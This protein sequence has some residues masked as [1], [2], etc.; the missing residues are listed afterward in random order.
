MNALSIITIALSAAYGALMV[1]YRVGWHRQQRA[2]PEPRHFQSDA[3]F[4]I[5]VPARNEAENILPLLDSIF[6]QRFPPDA[7]EAILVDDHSTDAT[8]S[9]AENFGHPNLT[10]VRLSQHVRDEALNAAKKRA[11]STGIAYA[12]HSIILTTDADCTAST[13]SW[14]IRHAFA[15]A[16]EDCVLAAGPVDFIKGRGVLYLFQSLDFMAMQGITAAAHALRL[17]T[18]SNGANLA[19]SRAAYEMVDGYDG[20]DHL[21]SGD[22]YLLTRKLA[23]QFGHDRL[24]YVLQRGAIVRTAAQLTWN[25]FLQQRIRWA[26]KSG[27]YNDPRLTAILMLV[28]AANVWLLTLAVLALFVPGAWKFLLVSL[29][30]KTVLEIFFL[31]PVAGFFGKRRELLVFPLLQPLHIL[32][33][34]LAGFMGMR[35]GYQWKGRSVR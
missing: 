17:G 12:Q 29:L 19:F 18:M 26:S 24:K 23:L 22:D 31:W 14:L 13:D 1:L 11:L 10:V 9:I 25:G 4:S 32:Y 28:Y 2:Q 35:G 6:S 16:D 5:V 3:S 27:K 20:I 33:I 15:F 30:A 34:V 7:F 21:A 8:A